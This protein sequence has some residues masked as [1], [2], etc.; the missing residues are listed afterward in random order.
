MLTRKKIKNGYYVSPVGAKKEKCRIPIVHFSLLVSSDTLR[1][2]LTKKWTSGDVLGENHEVSGRI[3][4]KRPRS[5]DSGEGENMIQNVPTK[6]ERDS[7]GER[8]LHNIGRKDINSLVLM[9]E[10]KD[11]PVVVCVAM[12]RTNG[13]L[14]TNVKNIGRVE[15]KTLWHFS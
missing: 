7:T 5:I 4:K 11:L 1:N 10:L 14:E 13:V 9:D 6:K 12:Y 8:L 15:G 3:S 2:D